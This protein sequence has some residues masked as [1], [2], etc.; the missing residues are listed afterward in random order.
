MISVLRTRIFY[1]KPDVLACTLTTPNNTHLCL[2]DIKHF[3]FDSEGRRLHS[4]TH[5][6][7][8]ELDKARGSWLTEKAK[9]TNDSTIQTLQESLSFIQSDRYSCLPL[10]ALPDSYG[11]IVDT[12][13]PEVFSNFLGLP[14]PHCRHL[15]GSWVGTASYAQPVDEFGNSI[16]ASPYLP[17]GDF[18]KLSRS[19][20]LALLGMA[21]QGGLTAHIEGS[22]FFQD[23]YHTCSCTATYALFAILPTLKNNL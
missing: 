16:A 8:D 5:I 3:G 19:I 20:Q 22:G 11:C 13:L 14:S 23:V 4:S 10:S 18:Q 2:Q 21:K 12:I 17:G 7:T 15:V 6:I 9:D 1:F